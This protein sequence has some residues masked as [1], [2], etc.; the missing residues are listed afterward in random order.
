MS[1]TATTHH[2]DEGT[3]IHDS[4]TIQPATLAQLES[5]TAPSADLHHV[6]GIRI[7]SGWPHFHEAVP[8]TL[9]RLR[10]HPDEGEWWMHLFLVGNDLVGSGGFCG[11]PQE[12]IAEIGYE[13]A[14][15]HQQRGH[16]TA[17]AAALVAKA[18]DHPDVRAVAAHTPAAEGPSARVLRRLGFRVV[19]AVDGGDDG[20]LWR[21][22][23][24]RAEVV[25]A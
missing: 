21:W 3:H 6:L 13:I 24:T 15:G 14:P 25:G 20:E 2:Q 10:D 9:S 12:G 19:A 18:F 7:P 17:A 1:A 5:L 8:F 11:P 16:A 4:L 23:L 22:E